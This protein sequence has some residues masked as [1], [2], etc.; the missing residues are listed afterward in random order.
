MELLGDRLGEPR[1]P[2]QAVQAPHAGGEKRV[3]LEHLLL[4]LRLAGIEDGVDRLVE[5]VIEGCDFLSSG[6]ESFFALQVATVGDD[7]PDLSPSLL[8]EILSDGPSDEGVVEEL[9][10]G[11]GPVEDFV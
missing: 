7:G 8:L 9:E 10:L 2:L 4:A 11:D 1:V 3:A 5:V 6:V